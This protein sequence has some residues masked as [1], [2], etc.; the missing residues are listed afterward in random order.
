MG[1]P[2]SG[3]PRR[4]FGPVVGNC[5]GW[6]VVHGGVKVYRGNPAAARTYVEA[7]HARVDDYYLAEGTGLAMRFVATPDGVVAVGALDGDGYEAWVAGLDPL[8][9]V[10]RGRLRQDAS[11][12]RFVEVVVN[13]PKT[14]S[15]AA[16]LDPEVAEAYDAAQ[17]RAA[18]ATSCSAKSDMSGGITAGIFKVADGC[19]KYSFI[20]VILIP[21]RT[22]AGDV[23]PRH[24]HKIP[25]RPQ[26]EI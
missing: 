5:W 18:A 7:D 9:R 12:V 15:L 13:G 1:R 24:L 23:T 6:S 10:P 19:S 3:G 22:N 11:A 26:G 4:I 8:S 17:D 16:A 14:W 21:P 25:D 2:V 20:N